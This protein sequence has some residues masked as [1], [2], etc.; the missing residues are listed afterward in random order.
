MIAEI[1]ETDV[2]LKISFKISVIHKR[3]EVS[4]TNL[5]IF[6]NLEW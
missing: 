3:I 4:I 6:R 5:I 2:F 1:N